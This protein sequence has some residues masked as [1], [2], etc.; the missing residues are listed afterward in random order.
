[1]RK[2]G[3][4]IDSLGILDNLFGNKI[5]RI[6]MNSLLQQLLSE[7]IEGEVRFDLYSKALYSTDASLYQ[8]E[9]IGVVIPLHKTDILRTIQICYDQNVPVL[10][11]GG[12]T[13]LA[14]QTV[15]KAIV[16]DT[17]KYMNKIIEVNVEENWAKVQPGIVLD[18]L[19][20]HLKPH[21]LMYAPDVATSSRA[22]VGGTIGNNS[23][24]S[25][26]VIYG[27]TID[28]VMSLD[29][30]LSNG[31]EIV[32]EPISLAR[33]KDKKEGN[34][35]E[36]HIYREIC[37]LAEENK[38]EIRSRYPR[39]L[40]RVAGYNLDEFIPNAGSK[41]VTPYRRDG[42]DNERPFNLAKIIVGS[43]GTLATVTEAKINLVP[44][45][46]MTTLNVIHFETLIE[47]MEAVQP[48]LECHPTAV[49]LI[50]DSIIKMN[51]R[52]SATL[53][54]ATLKQS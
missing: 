48:I 35:N 3:T 22:N 52:G 44:T 47:A 30:I 46:K 9:P 2:R 37:R 13:S 26:S 43:E 31:E 21:G 5:Q 11:R 34:T 24:G 45:P 33:L 28:H 39:I 16:I 36:A 17:S 19:N 23:A 42:C 6:D 51:F 14:G 29:L 1:M 25:H 41:E 8:I 50:D 15:G 4:V 32:A 20:H 40:R 49:E 12:G 53:F 10:P 38:E 54:K 27:K 7:Q 18:E